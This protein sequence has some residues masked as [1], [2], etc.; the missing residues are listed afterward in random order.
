MSIN[1][2]GSLSL[3]F[4]S[5]IRLWPPASSFARPPDAWSAASAASS[6]LA[7]SYSKGAGITAVS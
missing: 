7:R 6:D 5:G 1:R 4:I 2:V 3:S